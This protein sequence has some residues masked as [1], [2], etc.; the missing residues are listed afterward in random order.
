LKLQEHAVNNYI[1]T[2]FL[3]HNSLSGALQFFLSVCL[4][5]PIWVDHGL[6][7]M[8]SVWLT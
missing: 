3:T 4:V 2:F 6:W 5:E 1:N 8:D 7:W